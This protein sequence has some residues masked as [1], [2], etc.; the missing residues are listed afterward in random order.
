MAE[1]RALLVDLDATELA[2]RRR[3]VGPWLANVATV[4]GSYRRLL[5][6]TTRLVRDPLVREWLTGMADTAR[7]HEEAVRDLYE[8]FDV[9]P[10][11]P[12]AVVTVTGT[13]L[14]AARAVSGQV[15]GLL[16]GGSGAA[17]R[18]L[19][20]LQLTNLD[21]MS[22]FA[23]AQQFGLAEGRPRVVE[24]AFPVVTEKSQQQLL[25]QELFLEFA[26]DAVLGGSDV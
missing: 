24:I 16:S 10:P 3:R 11:V 1:R 20:Q 23:A 25:L 17:W 2:R 7:R 14:G 8:A 26:A 6:G 15:Q 12:S 4:Q 21:A 22:G 18:N 19:R 9:Q 5:V 13:V